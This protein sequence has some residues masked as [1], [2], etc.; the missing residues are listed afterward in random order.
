MSKYARTYHLP[1]S[2]GSTNDDR[3]SDNVNSLL[4]IE[5]VIT[6]KIEEF[7]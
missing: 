2:P 4:D 7:L 5:I 1:W 3:I 6:E